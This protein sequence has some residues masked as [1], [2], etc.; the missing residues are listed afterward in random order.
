MT[1]SHYEDGNWPLQFPEH[2]SCIHV[3][4]YIFEDYTCISKQ[5]ARPAS[6]TPFK[7]RF[8]GGPMTARFEWYIRILFFIKK[9]CQS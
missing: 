2:L 8:Y 7:W 5:H 6:E 4:Q 1:Y 3:F 9:N